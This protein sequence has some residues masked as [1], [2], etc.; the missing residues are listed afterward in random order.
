MPPPSFHD[1]FSRAA[2]DYATF[3]PRYP[4]ALFDFLAGRAPGRRLA[5]DCATG[6]GQ[7]ATALAAHFDR[8]IATHASAEQL[9]RATP[10]ARVEYRVAR[11]ESSGLGGASAAL[12]TVAQA[13]H[14]FDLPAFYA[15]A[16]RVLVR[17]GVLAVWCYTLPEVSP[18]VDARLHEFYSETVGAYWPPERALTEDGYASLPFP[19]D[20]FAVPPFSIEERL[21]LEG[22]LGYVGTWSAV[23]RFR[24]ARGFDPVAGFARLLAPAWGPPDAARL[25]RRPLHVR[26]GVRPDGA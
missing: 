13:V 19:F 7:A 24:Q 8:V 14:W 12:I 11:A 16:A 20:E 5:W 1:H 2:P 22:F 18:E 17:R 15:E 25:V 26:A 23:Q 6:N 10:H 3:R 4:A 9:A 21:T